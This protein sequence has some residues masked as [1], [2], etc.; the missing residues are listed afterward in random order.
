MKKKYLLYNK[1]FYINKNNIFY[2]F[3]KKI[4]NNKL[5]DLELIIMYL[6]YYNRKLYKK[7]YILKINKFPI[8]YNELLNNYKLRLRIKLANEERNDLLFNLKEYIRIQIDQG[9]GNILKESKNIYPLYFYNIKN[10]LNI[11][12]NIF[13]ISSFYKNMYPKMLNNYYYWITKEL[14]YLFFLPIIK[15]WKEYSKYY[16]NNINNN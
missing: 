12:S 10:G 5:S 1:Y 9:E 6:T 16:Y 8:I 7:K 15:Y 11:I 3:K 14:S 4:V 13:I 2:K